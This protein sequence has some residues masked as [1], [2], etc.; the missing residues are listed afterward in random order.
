MPRQKNSADAGDNRLPAAADHPG[1]PGEYNGHEEDKLHIA[2]V[3][4]SLMSRR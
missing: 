1:F 4:S 3:L 2:L